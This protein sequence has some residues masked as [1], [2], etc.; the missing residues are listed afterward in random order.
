MRFQSTDL[1]SRCSYLGCLEPLIASVQRRISGRAKMAARRAPPKTELCL[2]MLFDTCFI[3]PAR[4]LPTCFQFLS[5]DFGMAFPP[6]TRI[7]LV[8]SCL[9]FATSTSQLPTHTTAPSGFGFL[10][11]KRQA[12]HGAA[13]RELG[14]R[15]LKKRG[16]VHVYIF[17]YIHIH[18]TCIIICINTHQTWFPEPK[19]LHRYL[20]KTRYSCGFVYTCR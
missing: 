15:H 2:T 1:R 8:C 10:L 13:V 14:L 12:A 7:R 20:A 9:V 6:E 5:F 4:I 19:F 11:G 3:E 16:S 18:Y 17:F